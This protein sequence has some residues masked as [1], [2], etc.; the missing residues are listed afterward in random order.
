[1]SHDTETKSATN[2][3]NLDQLKLKVPKPLLDAKLAWHGISLDTRAKFLTTVFWVSTDDTKG[4]E[5]ALTDCLE[6]VALYQLSE[7]M[8]VIGESGSGKTWLCKMLARKYP[9]KEL[10][11][12]TLRPFVVMKVPHPCSKPG[13]T[14]AL[15]EALKDPEPT[16]GTQRKRFE[17]AIGLFSDCA[18]RILAVDNFHDIPERRDKHGVRLVGNWFRDLIEEHVKVV[19]LP[20]G[21]KDAQEVRISNNQVRRRVPTV[22]RL[23]YFTLTTT[24]GQRR[25]VK[26]LFEI[27]LALPL[28]EF[29][30]LAKAPLNSRL[31]IASNGVFDYL[32]KLIRR[33]IPIAVKAGR[34]RIELCDL[35][36][37]YRSM[38]GDVEEASN[39][40]SDK[41]V[42]RELTQIDDPFYAF[43]YGTSP[44]AKH[45]AKA[46]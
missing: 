27:D 38:H 11:D 29:S 35:H 37:A 1:M 46:H 21:T 2:G 5:D 39:P 30:D 32:M 15:L 9:D 22:K 45:V 13:L 10:E 36:V 8:L 7:G 19:F 16:Q 3:D 43:D 20:L 23:D 14:T 25:W 24:D 4:V 18:V 28:A 6:Q 41:F 12:R 34:E 31:F 33:A 44:A 17:R 26:L 42:Q 40:F